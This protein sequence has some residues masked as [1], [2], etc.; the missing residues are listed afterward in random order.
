MDTPAKGRVGVATDPAKAFA[1]W[2]EFVAHL[3][4]LGEVTLTAEQLSAI[5]MLA[6]FHGSANDLYY[7]AYV[8]VNDSLAN[9]S[10]SLNDLYYT[11]YVRVNDSLANKSS[12]KT[13]LPFALQH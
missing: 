11:A 13:L 2:D 3:L 1:D 7:T 8:R 4:Y 6:S 10:S 9:K 5:L 12:K